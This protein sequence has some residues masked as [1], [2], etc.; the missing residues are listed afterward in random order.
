MTRSQLFKFMK[1]INEAE[2]NGL[3]QSIADKHRRRYLVAY[4]SQTKQTRKNSLLQ[5]WLESTVKLGYGHQ[6][7]CDLTHGRDLIVSP[8]RLRI[9]ES[10]YLVCSICGCTVSHSIPTADI[11]RRVYGK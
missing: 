5:L 11:C 9:A 10:A 7:G 2:Q 6:D 8:Y 4:R 3:D 1:L